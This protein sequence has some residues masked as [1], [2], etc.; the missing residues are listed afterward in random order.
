MVVGIHVKE[1]VRALVVEL[2]EV[3]KL[4]E[5]IVVVCNVQKF[6]LRRNDVP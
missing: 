1:E 2:G 6:V 4:C 3:P 5:Q